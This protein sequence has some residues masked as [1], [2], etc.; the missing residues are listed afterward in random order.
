M[1]VSV[2]D[3]VVPNGEMQDLTMPIKTFLDRSEPDKVPNPFDLV[4][5]KDFTFVDMKPVGAEWKIHHL[6]LVGDCHGSHHAHNS[7]NGHHNHNDNHGSTSPH[8][9]KGH[10]DSH[11]SS[12]NHSSNHDGHKHENDHS[13]NHHDHTH[14]DHEHKDHHH[15]S[16]KPA[17]FEKE[18]GN[19]GEKTLPPTILGLILIAFMFVV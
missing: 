1:Y 17:T 14:G 8:S 12:H 13:H 15:S 4:H 18:T 5:L 3:F 6:E 2:S 11:D 19:I 10:N 16:N 7:S 9:D